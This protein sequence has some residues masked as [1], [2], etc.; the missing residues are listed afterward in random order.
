MFTLPESVKIVQLFIGAA[1]TLGTAT[2]SDYICCKNAVKVWVMLQHFGAND[3]DLTAIGLQEST[4]VAA[5]T[6]AAVAVTFPIWY[7]AQAAYTTSDAWTRATD[8]TAYTP[9]DPALL[10]QTRLLFE[11]DP[12]KHTAGYDCIALR[13]AGGHA[14][15]FCVVNAFIQERYQQAAPPAVITD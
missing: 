13:C 7:T 10:G 15:N 4:D 2:V 9:L 1:D 6:T 14:S 12:A 11:W 3:T 5:G 8:A